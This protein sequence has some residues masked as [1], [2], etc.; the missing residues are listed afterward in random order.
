MW[1]IC[2]LPSAVWST[3]IF[4]TIS[5]LSNEPL[6]ARFYLALPKTPFGKIRH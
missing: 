6:T 1:D 3:N 5:R 4:L 2:F